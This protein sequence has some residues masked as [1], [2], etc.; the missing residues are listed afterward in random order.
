MRTEKKKGMRAISQQVNKEFAV[1]D[2]IMA[3]INRFTRRE[4]SADEVY[5]FPV[6]LCDNEVDRDGERFSITALEKLGELFVGKTGIFDH[7]PKGENQ[8][9][10]IFDTKVIKDGT[11]KTSVGED[12]TYLEGKAYILKSEKNKELISEID[13]GIKKE[14]SVSCSVKKEICS[15]CHTDRRQKMCA[16]VKGK[17]YKNQVCHII[18][19]EPTD[20]YEFSFVAIP[21]QK[22]AGVTKSF[23][24]DSLI[25]D[26]CGLYYLFDTVLPKEK[27]E[28]MLSNRTD[29]EL[30]NLKTTLE[31]KLNKRAYPQIAADFAKEK[32]AQT[33]PYSLN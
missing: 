19:D 22:N 11:K 15:V 29:E 31:N 18:L 20:A 9:A 7:N 17:V 21:A 5:T 14:V 4:F 2:E 26:V 1:D 32:Q 6:V 10:R 23:V 33:S 13:G 30:L 27:V 28:K 8:T 16:H 3:K 24:K 25:K 12:Y